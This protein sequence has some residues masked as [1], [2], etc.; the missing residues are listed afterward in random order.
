SGALVVDSVEDAAALRRAHEQG[1]PVA[2]R[3]DDVLT[4]A[5][6][7]ARPEVSC[8]VVTDARLLDLDLAELTYG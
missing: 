1:V 4:V 2:V 7:L 8:V 3:A 5:T 6:A